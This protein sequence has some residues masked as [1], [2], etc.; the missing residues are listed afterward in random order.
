MFNDKRDAPEHIFSCIKYV[1]L[2]DAYIGYNPIVDPS[3]H[4]DVQSNEN[5][6]E[7]LAIHDRW[8]RR[9]HRPPP[10]PLLSSPSRPLFS[11]KSR[12]F[13]F[14]FCIYIPPMRVYCPRKIR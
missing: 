4:N 14:S 12:F 3:K 9:R 11:I 10:A 8:R 13:S 6:E 1:S 2:L 5:N 7:K